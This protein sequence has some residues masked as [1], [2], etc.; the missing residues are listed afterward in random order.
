MLL[1]RFVSDLPADQI[2]LPD[3]SH[4]PALVLLAYL[5]A[6]AAGYTA[7]ALAGRVQGSSR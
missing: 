1:P 6:S 7:L 4:S 3:C 2:A 5:I